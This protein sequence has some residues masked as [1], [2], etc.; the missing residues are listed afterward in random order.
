MA[1]WN[2]TLV[3]PDGEEIEPSS[4]LA[5]THNT[6]STRQ[7]SA[8][9]RVHA[10]KLRQGLL[11]KKAFETLCCPDCGR[12]HDTR[13]AEADCLRE[14]VRERADTLQRWADDGHDILSKEVGA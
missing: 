13:E 10:S 2:P 1:G 4:K 6:T 7:P 9:S 11:E 12:E 3:T 14:H 8:S 5:G